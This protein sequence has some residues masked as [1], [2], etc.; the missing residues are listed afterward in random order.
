MGLP[1][2]KSGQFKDLAGAIAGMILVI[3]KVCLIMLGGTLGPLR[4][5]CCG[6]GSRAGMTRSIVSEATKLQADIP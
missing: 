4:H 6:S 2:T 3:S 1:G 5:G